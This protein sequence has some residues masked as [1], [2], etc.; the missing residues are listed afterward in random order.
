[1]LCFHFVEGG[2]GVLGQPSREKG[3]ESPGVLSLFSKLGCPFYIPLLWSFV[4]RWLLFLLFWAFLS[5]WG[6]SCLP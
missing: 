5:T 4:S 1:M 2:R 3:L 6:S